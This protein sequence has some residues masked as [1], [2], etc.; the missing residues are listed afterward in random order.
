LTDSSDVSVAAN[1]AIDIILFAVLNFFHTK[2]S[3]PDAK[4]QTAHFTVITVYTTSLKT[5]I[6]ILKHKHNKNFF[7]WKP[8]SKVGDA[9]SP[10]C[11]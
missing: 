1:A 9:A 4:M 10:V 11:R 5:Q 3:S 8:K 2:T 6:Q 7:H